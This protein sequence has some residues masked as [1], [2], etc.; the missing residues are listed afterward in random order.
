MAQTAR[1]FAALEA[2]LADNSAGDITAVKLRDFLES[3]LGCYG[4]LRIALGSTAE[5]LTA[6][7]AKVATWL[8]KG[9]S[10]NT[11]LTLASGVQLD[12]DGIWFVSFDASFLVTT[13]TDRFRFALRADNV[14]VP[15]FACEVTGVLGERAAVSFAD[16]Y[17]A[18]SG[19]ELSIYAEAIGAAGDVTIENGR[20]G[21]HRVG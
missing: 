20:F 17:P 21:A 9:P 10:R 4:S 8:T 7:P 19:V 1:S 18:T 5:V 3:A 12:S 2:L 16:S 15:G 14:E 6:T 13:S 11:A